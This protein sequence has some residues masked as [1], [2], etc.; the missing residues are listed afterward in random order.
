MKT[1]CEDVSLPLL[2]DGWNITY[3]LILKISN[4][5]DGESRHCWVVFVAE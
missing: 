4:A 3:S 5:V 1:C 2:N